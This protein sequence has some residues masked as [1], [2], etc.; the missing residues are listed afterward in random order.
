MIFYC[1][2]LLKYSVSKV[3]IIVIESHCSLVNLSANLCDLCGKK[4]KSI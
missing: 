2:G 3:T 4:K 1:F